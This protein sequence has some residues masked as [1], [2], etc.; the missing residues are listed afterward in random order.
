MRHAGLALCA[1][2]IAAAAPARAEWKRAESPHFIVYSRGD[3]GT[4]RRYVRALELYDYI[5]RH[6]T[7]LPL[8]AP[9]ARKL[10]IYLVNN[11]A[12]LVAINPGTRPDVRG[13]YF[14]REEDIFSTA[15][16]DGEMDYLLHE[17]FHHF[18]FQ[19]G[20]TGNYPGWLIEGLA[21]YYMTAEITDDSVRIGGFNENRTDW[22]MNSTWLSLEDL[23]SKR[24]GGLPSGN[25]RNTYYPV[26]WLLTHWFMGD[27][28]R[29]TQ[30]EAY[31]AQVRG[32]AD[33][34]AA[35]QVATGMTLP[36][37]TQ[38][39][40]RYMRGL[41]PVTQYEINRPAPEIVVT[42]LPASADDLLLIGQRLKIGVK[43]EDR[44]E[45]AVLVRRLAARYPDD[46]F[47]MLQLGHAELHFGDPVA[48]EAVLTRLLEREPDNIEALQ[49][50][51]VRYMSLAEEGSDEV[52]LRASA[53]AFLARAYSADPGQYYTLQL[54][55]R[56]RQGQPGYPN[57]NDLTTWSLAFD[58]APQLSS[59][60]LGYTSALMQAGEFDLAVRLLEPLANSP[61]GGSASDAAQK[62]L[63]RARAG[64][65]PLTDEELEAATEADQPSQPEPQPTPADGGPSTTPQPVAPGGV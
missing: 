58:I 25:D 42:S 52:A 21:E 53:R 43:A 2:T 27:N 32:G 61:H 18:S 12:G 57:E 1:L 46:S 50:M 54:L 19:M 6:R 36:A 13:I 65:P 60:R 64:Q 15:I 55:A 4:L 49:L 30:L 17:Y 8:E 28:T 40:R 45:T 44:A 11:R 62:L 23:L 24:P 59:T 63:E 48:G 3:E 26:A 9:V 56:N 10:P 22:L 33:P 38:E 16:N 39:L 37:L 5:L 7:G 14:P 41:L 29:R 31:I 20:S 34:V 35:M 47:A 51:A